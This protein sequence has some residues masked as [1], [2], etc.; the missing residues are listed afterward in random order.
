MLKNDVPVKIGGGLLK[1]M[2][3]VLEAVRIGGG[4]LKGIEEDVVVV[5]DGEESE[6]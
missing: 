4:L 2:D 6:G 1:G 5:D 3:V